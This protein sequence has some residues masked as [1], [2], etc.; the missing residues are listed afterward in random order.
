MAEKRYTLIFYG[1]VIVAA[2]ATFGVYRVLQATK[3]NARV[4]TQPVVV[5]A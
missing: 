4:A 3:E 1:A 5:A 2:L